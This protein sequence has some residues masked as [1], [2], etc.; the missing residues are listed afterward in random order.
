M[1]IFDRKNTIVDRITHVST[2]KD[3]VDILKTKCGSIKKEIQE[4]CRRFVEEIN[5]QEILAVKKLDSITL[6]TENKIKGLLQI[7]EPLMKQYNEWEENSLRRIEESEKGNFEGQLELF[8]KGDEI[9]ARGNY[10]E[11]EMN[12]H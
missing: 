6:A 5:K 11:A 4:R 12:K 8:T 1:G 2:Q 3:L 10:F 9:L 7:E